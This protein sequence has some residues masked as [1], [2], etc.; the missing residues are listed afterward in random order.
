MHLITTLLV[1]DDYLV[2]KDLKK[3]LDWNA[4]GFEIIGTATNGKKALT[5]TQKEHPELIITDISM[6][7]MDGF[8]FV[9]TVQ[10]EY[11][12]SYFIFISSYADFDYAKRAMRDGIRDYILKNEITAEALTQRL[13]KVRQELEHQ[14]HHR[15]QDFRIKLTDYFK[16]GKNLSSSEESKRSYTFYFFSKWIPL[17]KLKSHFLHIPMYGEELYPLLLQLI[18]S[19]YTDALVFPVEEFVIA[20]IPGQKNSFSSRKPL[21][22]CLDIQ[23]ALELKSGQTIIASCFPEALTLPEGRQVYQRLLPF[24]HFQSSF[25]ENSRTVLSSLVKTPFVPVDRFFSYTLL[26]DSLEYPKRY[27]DSLKS[28]LE[29]LFKAKDADSIFML[30]HNLLLNM[31]ELSG[32]RLSFSPQSY[33]QNQEE[34]YTFLESSY[35]ELRKLCIKSSQGQYSP[36]VQKAIEYMK[37]HLSDSS[38]TVDQISAE[39]FLSA[40]RFGVLFKQETGQTVYDYLTELRISRAIHLLENTRMKIYEIAEQTG[41]KSSQYFSQIFSQRTGHKPLYFRQ[42]KPST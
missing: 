28:F 8:D 34:L 29:L 38:L 20:G 15:Q 7:I 42:K 3:M 6:P 13:L 23:Q 11:P 27:L 5:I 19:R 18:L 30:Y 22:N 2:L 21:Q 16:S 14:K 24:L 31:E 40:S 1:D 32:H 17:E 36:S 35:E 12:H 41:Y 33:F 4:L 25:P 10:K 9:E 26:K 37:S 39:V